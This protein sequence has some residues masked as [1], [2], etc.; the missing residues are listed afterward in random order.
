[1]PMTP[2][3]VR[4]HKTHAYYTASQQAAKL[5]TQGNDLVAT[6]GTKRRTPKRGH[7]AGMKGG[8]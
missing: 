3:N 6:A 1:M 8:Y 5:E 2:K 7:S 4:R